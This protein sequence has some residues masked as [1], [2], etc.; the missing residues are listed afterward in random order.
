[1]NEK[2]KDKMA[3]ARAAKKPPTYKNVHEDV[4]ALDD[5]HYLSLKKVKEWEKHNKL[6]VKELKPLI[7]KA[8]NKKDKRTLERELMNRQA[9]IKYLA[10]YLDTATWLDLFYGKDQEHLM[11]WR[12]IA[13]A[14]DEEGYVK[15]SRPP[16]EVPEV[17]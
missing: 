8:D 2:T 15:V 7:R 11:K 3:R 14:Y 17:G 5:D 4:K 13:V 6:R 12:T 16:Y 9:Y 1:M 10:T